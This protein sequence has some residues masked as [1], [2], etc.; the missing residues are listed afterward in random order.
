MA[1]SHDHISCSELVELVTDYLEGALPADQ[2]SLF[3]EHLNLCDG[4]VLY[5]DQLEQTVALAGRLRVEDLPAE[6]KA[7]LLTA[8]S[9]WG[10]R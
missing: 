5:V 8:F 9:E 6:A 1:E 3:E 10:S 4:C 2:R 7:R